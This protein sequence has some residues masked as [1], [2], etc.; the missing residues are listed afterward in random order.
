MPR[1]P[2]LSALAEAVWLRRDALGLSQAELAARAGCSTRFIHTL[3]H[4]KATLRLD[5]VLEVL[6]VLKLDL[7]VCPGRGEV[8]A[9]WVSGPQG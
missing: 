2:D 6:A 5:K 8:T 3:E 7:E 1:P 9:R 4:G